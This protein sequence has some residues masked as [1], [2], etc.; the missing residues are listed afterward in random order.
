MKRF[1]TVIFQ[2]S[3]LVVAFQIASHSQTSPTKSGVAIRANVTGTIEGRQWEYLVISFGKVYF[4]DPISDVDIKTSGLSKLISFSKAGIVIASEGITTQSKMDTLGR[5]GWELVGTV[6]AIGGDQEMLFKRPYLPERSKQ[7][8]ELIKQEG[9]FAKAKLAEERARNAQLPS[10]NV[11]VDMDQV[12][13]NAARRSKNR[14]KQEDRLRAA[15]DSVRSSP[16]TLTVSSLYS[17]ASNA[18]DSDVFASVTVDGTPKLL[19]DGN[20]FRSSEADKL[21]KDIG[22][23]IF[24]SAQLRSKYPNLGERS[25]ILQAM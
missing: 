13:R 16:L 18:T 21:A 14:K 25:H 9:E 4:S 6:G 10:A 1:A 8:E 20:K 11:L 24:N 3:I 15:V 22:M 7:E 19:T 5:F 12:E 2:I 23:E 17:N